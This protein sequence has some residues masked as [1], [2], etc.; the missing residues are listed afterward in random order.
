[1]ESDFGASKSEPQ[2]GAR[3]RTRYNVHNPLEEDSPSDSEGASTKK[4]KVFENSEDEE[5][6]DYEDDYDQERDCK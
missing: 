3:Q 2:E 4:F 6:D 5:E 1:M